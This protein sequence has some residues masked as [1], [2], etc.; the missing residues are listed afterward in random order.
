MYTYVHYTG[1]YCLQVQILGL[2]S[3]AMLKIVF[4]CVQQKHLDKTIFDQQIV[5]FVQKKSKS[6]EPALHPFK[7]YEISSMP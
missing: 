6:H 1:D 4:E 7:A 5:N 3:F 2:S